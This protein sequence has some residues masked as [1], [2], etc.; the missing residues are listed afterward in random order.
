MA[1]LPFI[2]Q[3]LFVSAF[4]AAFSVT[5]IRV[6][7]LALGSRLE[8]AGSDDEGSAVSSPAWTAALGGPE[9]TTKPLIGL[10]SQA[11]HRCPGKYALSIFFF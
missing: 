4:L 3:I 11:C 2:C 1:A 10:L 5:G 7:D 6:S 8:V 9:K